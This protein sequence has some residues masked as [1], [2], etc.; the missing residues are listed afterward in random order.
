[1]SYLYVN[2]HRVAVE[3]HCHLFSHPYEPAALA[4][5]LP[6]A[7]HNWTHIS[8]CRPGEG[9]VLQPGFGTGFC[10]HPSYWKCSW[11][12]ET[13]RIMHSCTVIS[14]RELMWWHSCTPLFYFLLA[15]IILQITA[16][17]FGKKTTMLLNASKKIVYFFFISDSCN[18]K[19]VCLILY[20]CCFLRGLSSSPTVV[21]M[22]THLHLSFYTDRLMKHTQIQ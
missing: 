12:F 21:H 16:N 5:L 4:G 17:N 13:E 9:V 2:G 6:A 3:L 22:F 19:C 1:M 14:L 20:L 8:F 10:P 15:F 18:V 11:T 7:Q